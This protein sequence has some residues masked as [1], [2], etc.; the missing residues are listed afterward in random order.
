[1]NTEKSINEAEGN[2][3]LRIVSRSKMIKDFYCRRRNCEHHNGVKDGNVLCD[4]KKPEIFKD[5]DGRLC[6]NS[7]CG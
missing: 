2:A 7:Y 4:L 3:V 1:M 5:K 6:C